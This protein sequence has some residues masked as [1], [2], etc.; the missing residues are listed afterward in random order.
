MPDRT[1]L[2]GAVSLLLTTS[3]LLGVNADIVGSCPGYVA[4]NVQNGDGKITA[5]L[6]LA[7][8]ACNAYGT[9]LTDLRLLVEYQ[10]EQRLHV[11][12]YDAEEKVYQVPAQVVSRP[13][14][15]FISEGCDMTFKLQADPFSFT[16]SRSSTGEILF[17]T[18]GSS[19]IFESQYLRLRT[20]LPADPN[21][22][23]LGESAD[24]LRLPTSNYAHTFWNAG[25]P[26]IP[27]GQ[28]LY[29][30]HNIYYDH[31]GSNGTHSVFFMNS[32]GI[33]VKIDKD[34]DG[35]QY[36]EYNALGGVFDFYFMIGSTPKKTSMQ[37]AELI[38]HA[39]LMPYWG[40]GFHQ[41]K[42]GWQD[43]YEVAGVVANYS[44]ANIPLETMW[45]DIDY[46][47]YRRTMSLDPLRFPLS[48]VRQVVDYLHEHQQH[49]IVMVDPAVARYPYTPFQQG[50]SSDSFLRKQ[51]GSLYTGVVWAGPSVFPDW[52]APNTQDYWT[53]QF[54]RFFSE[55][56]GVDIDG[57]WIDMNE[58]S[59]FCDEVCR[60]NPTLFSIHETAPPRPPPARMHS[61]YDVPG[62]PEE[63][64][65]HCVA[66]VTFNVQANINSTEEFLL[67]MG[68]AFA[69]GQN[70]PH[71]S[72]QLWPY[73]T[74][75]PVWNITVQLPARSTV[76]YQYVRY[77]YGT[78][79][80]YVRESQNRT[81]ETQGCNSLW[82][83]Y[84]V[85]DLFEPT[86]EGALVRRRSPSLH[87]ANQ[88]E[89][90]QEPPNVT[91]GS[92]LGLRGRELLYP[93]YNIS[94][95]WPWGNLSVQTIATNVYHMN[96]LVEYDVHNLYGSMMSTASRIAMEHRRPGKRPLIITRSTFAGAGREVGHWFGDNASEWEDYRISIR[97]MIEFAALFQFPMVGTDVCGF[98]YNATEHLC[99]RWT[100]LG[101]F[102]PFFRNH[103]DIGA[104]PQELYRWP[105]VGEAARNAISIRYRLLDYLYTAMYQQNQTG[106]PAI[107]PL[108]FLYPEDANTFDIQ[109]QFFFGDSILVSPVLSDNTT[110]VSAYI[111]D[112]I[113]YDFATLQPLRGHGERMAFDDIAYTEIPMHIRGGSI[114]PMRKKSANT[115][116]ELRK[117]SFTIV[118][119]PGLD[120]T[121]SGSLYFD[122]GQ[123]LVQPAISDISFAYSADG[124]FT[125]DGS[126]DYD[127]GVS[128]ESIT[129]LGAEEEASGKS[130]DLSFDS[131]TGSL[132]HKVQVSLQK[133]FATNLV[134]K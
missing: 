113:F 69:I 13:P 127:S 27:K 70:E 84:E 110:S 119:A 28:N 101:A 126:F 10:T 55:S 50:I 123:S 68:D 46:M 96:G 14:S 33:E 118:V 42:Y 112:D 20:H 36:L 6:R 89:R 5:D 3:T 49:Y 87:S 95:Y 19:L 58:A 29:G 132:T 35:G 25:E 26:L 78:D 9:D 79:G 43:I 117:Q 61:P 120:G 76:T 21:L 86:E 41:C 134:R 92:M 107:N 131:K 17:D 34:T 62:F 122:D 12:I 83:P 125:M 63:F 115:T 90:R 65:P 104:A 103:A 47:K 129:L 111:P 32:N 64:Q 73:D 37:Y 67:L 130:A 74:S 52:F 40:F 128:I 16:V 100:T 30:S 48:K 39:A 59:N 53:E 108:F 56:D 22:Y 124:N 91:P 97:Q 75:P 44:A 133:S 51:D 85:F 4:S 72:P 88:L 109:Q 11:K 98:N 114:I 1:W 116:T 2:R 45:T 23:G 66:Y 71:D 38:G 99:S 8:D 105:L 57:L 93:P 80:S 82:S 60:P 24:S 81:V 15:T 94:N 31:R 77:L 102:Y 18:S 54:A 7:G 106:A 121:A